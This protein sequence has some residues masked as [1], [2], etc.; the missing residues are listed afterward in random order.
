MPKVRA[1][2]DDHWKQVVRDAFMDGRDDDA[3]D[4]LLASVLGWIANRQVKR[5]SMKDPDTQFPSQIYVNW[6]SEEDPNERWMMIEDDL[7]SIGNGEPVAIYKLVT[8]KTKRIV[9]TLE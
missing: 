2:Q 3:I 8:V 4:L 5:T 9:G 7:D 1:K 6:T